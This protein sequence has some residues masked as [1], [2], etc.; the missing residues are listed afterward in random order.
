MFS[1]SSIDHDYKMAQIQRSTGG[2]ASD[3][4]MSSDGLTLGDH[5]NGTYSYGSQAGHS[6]PSLFQD[7]SLENS[8][9]T[10][11]LYSDRPNRDEV[12]H[13]LAPPGKLGMSIETPDDGIIMVHGIKTTS[14]IFDELKVGDRILALDDEDV[15]FYTALKIS[16]MITNKSSNKVRK[17]TVIRTVPLDIN[18]EYPEC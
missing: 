13:I 10:Q 1:I 3:R 16:K 15:R 9:Y 18:E 11:S 6:N 4:T 12:I 8:S 5:T 17:L 7:S 2:E 14:P